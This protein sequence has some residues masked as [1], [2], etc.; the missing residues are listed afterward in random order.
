MIAS[1]ESFA[2][3]KSNCTVA[4]VGRDFPTYS[5][6]SYED[7]TKGGNILLFLLHGASLA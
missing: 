5:C 3:G 2:G 1:R 7:A 6:H 4:R